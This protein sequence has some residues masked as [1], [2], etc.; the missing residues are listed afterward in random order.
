MSEPRACALLARAPGLRA[1]H[2]R[3]AVAELGQLERI[4]EPQAA[5]R[6]H[7]LPLQ[8]RSFL[9]SPDE[10]RVAADLR[11]LATTGAHVVPCTSSDY[12]PLLAQ[13]RRAP[14]VLYVRGQ[15]TAL[16]TQ[17][18]AVVGAR[19]ATVAGR[20]TA[21]EFA[22]V[23]AQNGLSVTSGLAV[24]IDAAA[25]EGALAAGGLTIAVCAHGLDRIYPA[26][27][28]H[29]AER[30][31]D[32]GALV[33]ELPPGSCARRPHFPQR[34]RI[35]GGLARGTLVVEAARES[36][37]LITARSAFEHGR[38]VFAVPGPIRSALSRGC[39]QLIREGARLVESAQEVLSVLEIPLQEQGVASGLSTPDDALTRARPLDKGYEMLLDALGFEP[40]SVNML[41]ERTGLPSESL[42]SM[43]LILELGGRIAPHPGGRYC[44]L[45]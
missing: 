18:L 44:R 12:P 29:L 1:E 38:D 26:E 4:V 7:A 40:V 13:I 19:A 27:H 20:I 10:E 35:I 45:S 22:E 31:C 23:F 33:S 15:L 41:V 16:R 24:G 9:R 28:R 25:H 5:S 42:V 14:A 17:Q 37:S 32:Q 43:L 6:C 8:A 36:G 2:L 21:R 30:I 11:W 3:A 34:N 39:H